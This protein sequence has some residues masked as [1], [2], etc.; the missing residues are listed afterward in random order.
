MATLIF[1]D[2]ND[3]IKPEN[4][5]A[6]RF[7]IDA[8]KQLQAK[9]IELI[10]VTGKNRQK[11]EEFASDY[12]GSRYIITSNGGEVF[13]TTTREVIYSVPIAKIAIKRLYTIAQNNSLR[14][15]LNVDAD[16]RLTTRVKYFDGSEKELFNVDNALSEYKIIGGV[17]TDIPEAL[18]YEVKRQIFETDGV[19]ISNQGNN[20]GNNFIDFV[21]E[22]TN[23]GVAIRK[24]LK[25]LNADFKDT[26]SIGNERNDIPMF[27]ATN[28]SIV[29]SNACKE[30][31]SMVDEVI[32]GVEKDGVA[33]FFIKLVKK[34][35]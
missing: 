9:G 18:V 20:K 6:S 14:F 10:L 22:Y 8:I 30:I 5:V 16:Y 3:T 32:G 17:I 1:S 26:I 13:D 19:V 11:T 12:G 33:K 35:P 24:L 25:H 21:S 15:I 31:K 4:G 34:L 28:H 27:S 7:S 2:I 23:K 29:V